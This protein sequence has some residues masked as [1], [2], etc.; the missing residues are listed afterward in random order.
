MPIVLLVVIKDDNFLLDISYYT[1][2]LLLSRFIVEVYYWLVVLS[3]C[4]LI[5]HN[6]YQSFALVFGE[7]NR[8][9]LFLH[10]ESNVGSRPSNPAIR[11]TDRS[12]E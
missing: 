2:S 5:F 7:R 11:R 10:S 1:L 3:L 6:R 8:A 12:I 9:S 4:I